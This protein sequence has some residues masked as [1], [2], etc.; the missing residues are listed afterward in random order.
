MFTPHVPCLFFLILFPQYYQM[1]SGVN[2]TAFSL[3][4]LRF[5]RHRNLLFIDRVLPWKPGGVII[6]GLLKNA[7]FLLP[8]LSFILST[9]TATHPPVL[10]FSS[11]LVSSQVNVLSAS[12]N[13]QTV[14]VLFLMINLQIYIT[15]P[16]DSIQNPSCLQKTNSPYSKELRMTEVC[17]RSSNPRAQRFLHRG[18]FQRREDGKDIFMNNILKTELLF[19]VDFKE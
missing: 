16:T 10:S 17:K 15:P 19:Q 1:D 11:F 13:T 6:W 3:I 4:L 12:S 8:I 9:V 18:R 7:S 5:V 2:T 14:F